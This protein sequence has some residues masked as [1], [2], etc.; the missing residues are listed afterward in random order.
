MTNNEKANK[1]TVEIIQLP[2]A[3]WEKYK[4]LRLRALKEDPQAFGSNYN[5]S[6][7]FP[8][9]KWQER[10]QKVVD[11]E[12]WA[13]FARQGEE[14]VGMMF[15]MK[16]ADEGVVS[17]VSVYVANEARG[18]GISGRLMST[19]I[20][21]LGENKISL[22]KLSVNQDQQAAV[23]L[24][25][26]FGFEEVGKEDGIMGNGVKQTELLMEKKLN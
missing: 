22:I 13:V 24:Y 25:K 18:Q 1:S 8:D 4:E 26:K 15:A 9:T 19:I 7:M 2:V 20:R 14:L 21:Q 17:I 6:L 10:L 5:D 23:G 16:E 12:S 3:E 11:G